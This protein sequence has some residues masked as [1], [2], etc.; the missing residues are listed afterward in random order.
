MQQQLAA[1]HQG[2]DSRTR[3]RVARAILEG[4]P[5]T[6]VALADQLGLTPTAVRRHLDA[7]VDSGRVEAREQRVAGPRRR[8]RP[9]KE[10]ALTTSGHAAMTT[11]Y[12]DLAASALR[13][14]GATGGEQAVEAFARSRAA[15]IESR[16]SS[17]V[18]AAGPSAEERLRAL[19]DALSADG[20]AA[21]VHSGPA[22]GA[23]LCQGHCP[24]Q[25]VAAQFPQL[26]DAEAESFARLVGAPARRLSTLA[27]GEHVCTTHV[28]SSSPGSHHRGRPQSEAASRTTAPSGGTSR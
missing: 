27:H 23:Q 4:G 17:A 14:L 11:A 9:A 13:F 16:Y 6:A 18:E 21:S 8:G 28:S 26:C 10:F 12:D 19:A 15:E 20:Y 2:P 24:V 1:G 7:L 3:D 5:T 22:G 25:S